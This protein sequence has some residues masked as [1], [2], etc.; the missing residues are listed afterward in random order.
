MNTYFIPTLLIL[1]AIGSGIV[2]GVYFAFSSFVMKALAALP[3]DQGI[4]AMRSI[5]VTVIN[6]SFMLMFIGTTLL[7]LVLCGVA[8]Y[9]WQVRG[10]WI[11]LASC[12]AYL[13]GSFGVTVW[14][15]YVKE[16]T[17]WNSLR[18]EMSVVAMIGFLISLLAY[19]ENS[20]VPSICLQHYR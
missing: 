1:G 6:P 15:N 4:A 18:T 20:S 11:I 13:I 12:F 8:L 2:A 5:N 16:W 3:S 10:S 17:R 9:H 14:S 7:C 19:G